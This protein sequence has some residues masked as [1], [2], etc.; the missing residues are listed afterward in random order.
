MEKRGYVGPRDLII[1]I[2][3]PKKPQG[4]VK[5]RRK[6]YSPDQLFPNTDQQTGLAA[7]ESSG[8]LIR[9]RDP[10]PRRSLVGPG[11]LFLRPPAPE[12]LCAARFGHC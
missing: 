1:R 9:D 11:N 2:L 3:T 8:E 6:S 5:R 10:G 12:T 4:S 7:S